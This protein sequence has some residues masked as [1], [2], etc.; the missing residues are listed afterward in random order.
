MIWFSIDLR[1]L[2]Q[3]NLMQVFICKM[4][5]K[6]YKNMAI[7]STEYGNKLNLKN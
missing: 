5:N 3:I 1:N 6:P 7:K 2:Y 4:N